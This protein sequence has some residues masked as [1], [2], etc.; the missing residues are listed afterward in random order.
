[1]SSRGGQFTLQNGSRSYTVK[2]LQSVTP[3]ELLEW[4]SKAEMYYILTEEESM[5][6]PLSRDIKD[7]LIKTNVSR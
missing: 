7:Q 4:M 1:M 2:V 6:Q 3:E 5:M